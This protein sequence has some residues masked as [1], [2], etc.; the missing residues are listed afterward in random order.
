MSEKLSKLSQGSHRAK[1]SFDGGE[2]RNQDR[3]S[4]QAP[5]AGSARGSSAAG[6]EGPQR[7]GSGPGA[8][9]EAVEGRLQL[10]L[11]PV[12][13]SAGLGV[14]SPVGE[15]AVAFEDDGERASPTK[16][17]G[18]VFSDTGAPPGE[19]GDAGRGSNSQVMSSPQAQAEQ[20]HKGSAG[21]L[22]GL[23]SPV[24]GRDSEPGRESGSLRG[25]GSDHA[26]PRHRDTSGMDTAGGAGAVAPFVPTLQPSG[27]AMLVM[28]PQEFD[29][30]VSNLPYHKR[31]FLRL[32]FRLRL[33]VDHPAF[34]NFFLLAILVNTILL[35]LEYDGGW[36]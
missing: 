35:A 14:G 28:T 9:A 17:R 7:K 2:P 6:Q 32:Q 11:V 29:E 13:G 34:N 3:G 27:A 30:F 10:A 5:G 12:A 18:V 19:N 20:G 16:R 24:P 22:S 21:N 26:P 8:V 23:T 25:M 36:V 4:K 1:G 31:Q 15:G 33:L